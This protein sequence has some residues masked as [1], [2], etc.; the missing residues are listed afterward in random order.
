MGAPPPPWAACSG[1]WSPS[2]WRN[3]SFVFFPVFLLYLYPVWQNLTP[4]TA[5]RSLFPRGSYLTLGRDVSY[6]LQL[7]LIHLSL[8]WMQGV[9][10]KHM[11]AAL[12]IYRPPWELHGFWVLPG[13]LA[14]KISPLLDSG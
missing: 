6:L 8:H 9:S 12:L 13:G 1:A 4:C 10:I 5:L 7:S 14:R 2:P 11:D 3:S